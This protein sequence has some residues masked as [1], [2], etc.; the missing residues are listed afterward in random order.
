MLFYLAS[1]ASFSM[2]SF[3]HFAD[4]KVTLSATL[5]ILLLCKVRM[6]LDLVGGFVILNYMSYVG[7]GDIV[8]SGL[9][10]TL[11]FVALYM[12]NALRGFGH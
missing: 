1:P 5:S 4:L 8:A 2:R 10:V 6:R 3:L 12:F 7:F 9:I 11:R